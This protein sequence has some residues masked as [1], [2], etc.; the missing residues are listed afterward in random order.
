MAAVNFVHHNKKSEG[1]LGEWGSEANE[2]SLCASVDHSLAH[3]LCVCLQGVAGPA[4]V[5]PTSFALLLRSLSFVS[6][7]YCDF[8]PTCY[9]SLFFMV[10]LS[11]SLLVAQFTAGLFDGQRPIV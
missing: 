11:S 10:D 1:Q 4:M 8:P 9:L 5:V 6:T 2:W 7:L 3:V